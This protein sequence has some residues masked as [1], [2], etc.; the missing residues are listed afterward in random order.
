MLTCANCGERNPERAR[1]CLSCGAPLAAERRRGA[2]KVVTVV[3][4]DV[5]GSTALGERLDPESLGRVMA[6]FFE[7]TKAV[8]ERHHGLVQKFVGDA[9]VAVFGVPVV[10]EDDALRAVRAAAAVQDA[11]AELD[12]D[13]GPAI[14]V[15]IG[16]ATGEV[17]VE[18]AGGDPLVIGEAVNLASRLQAAAGPG[19][20][21]LDRRTWHLSRDAL[22]A[23]PVDGLGLDGGSGGLM[24]RPPVD[25]EAWRLVDVSPD[26]LGHARSHDSPLVGRLPE[27]QLFDWVFQRTVRTSTCHLLTV[28]G[29][30]GVGKS[31]LVTAAVDAL[32]DAATALYGQCPSDAEGSSFWPIAEIVRRA[33]E[34]KSADSPEQAEAKLEEL[35]A[36]TKG[37]GEPEAADRLGRLIGLQ[38]APVPPED[39]VWAVR[40]FLEVLAARR[41]LVVVIDDLHWAQPSLL[42]LLEQVVALAREAPILLVAVARPELLEQRPA[43]SG[44]RLNASTLLLEPL[45]ADESATLLEHLAGEVSLPAEATVR[46]TRTAEGNPLFLEELLAMLIEEGRLRRDGGRWVADDLA[47]VSTPPTIQAL[48]AARL[49]RL[50]GEER[51]LLDRAS[52]MG[53]GFDRSALQAL[54][55]APAREAVDAHLLALVRKEL[56]RPAHAPLGGRDG[57]Q[58]RHQLARD[59][60]YDSLPKQARAELHQRYADWLARTLGERGREVEEVLGWHLER[61]HRLLTELGPVDS[62]GRE[63]AAAAAERLASAGRTATGRGDLPAAANLLERAIALLPPADR[64]RLHLLTELGEVLTLNVETERAERVLDEALAAADRT[65][66]QGLR[67]HATLG[68]LELRLDSPDRGP[69]SYR[70]DVQQVLSLLE[71]LGDQQGQARAWRLLGLDSYLRCLIGRAEDEFQRAVDHARIANDERVEAGNLYALAQSAFWGPTPVAEG[72]RRCQEIRGRAEGSYRVEMS[73]LHTLAGLHAMQGDFDLARELGAAA[74]A[75]AG[76]L[77]PSR[78][79]ALCSQFLGQVELLAGDPAAAERW[80]RWGSGILEKMGERGLRSEITANL[81]RALAAQERDDEALEAATL[82]GELAVRDDLYAQVERRGPLGMVLARQGRPAEAERLAAEAVELARDSDMLAMQ[83]GALLDLAHVLRSAGRAEE[84]V[85]LLRQALRLA[86]R[87]GHLVAAGHAKD[88]LDA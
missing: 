14:E 85:P 42:D 11:V 27:L 78:F 84:A 48:L 51:A 80:L 39:A 66:D 74:V 71:G 38:P 34:I 37:T 3:V 20:V 18:E 55:P 40:R 63:L 35:L 73:A 47:G 64:T 43:W 2:R 88:L 50:A 52:V 68:K 75:I 70:A 46:I 53:Q 54:T 87:K 65:G 77:G 19:E 49:D 79:A 28:L 30:A 82:S 7:R 57:F 21:L 26:A 15:H 23:A 9:V 56:L 10:R 12:E 8:L 31:R 60:A 58:F 61:A 67:A 1:F 22:V 41:P 76:R 6:R 24:G 59:A 5:T 44:G 25:G 13:G 62:G 81:A 16:V 72:I 4:C 45:A 32:D 69:D 29:P 17:M 86:E 36:G 33:A 83:A